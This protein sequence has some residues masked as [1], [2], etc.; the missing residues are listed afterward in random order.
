MANQWLTHLETHVMRE[1]LPLTQL[2]IFCYIFRINYPGPIGAHRDWT[3]NQSLHG[4]DLG[5]LHIYNRHVPWSLFGS[6]NSRSRLCL[7]LCCVPLDA[8]PLRVS[9]PC[10][11]SIGE[12]ASNSTATLF[13]KVG[14]YPWDLPLP[15]REMKRD[16]RGGVKG[17]EWEERRK[18]KLRLKCKVNTLIN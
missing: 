9:L 7:W 14:W 11:V 6:P 5:S 13:D 16:R 8:L 18:G 12:V 1:N 15:W 10:L 3:T 2:I 4:I 17:R